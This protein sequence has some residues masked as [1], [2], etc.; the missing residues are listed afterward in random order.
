MRLNEIL[1]EDQEL[2]E[3]PLLNKIGSAVGKAAG[4]AAKAVG[5]VAG[6]IAGLGA[7][8]KK[9]FQAGKQ[10]VAGAGD[11]PAAGTTQPGAPAA[12]GGGASTQTPASTGTTS[13][14]SGGPPKSDTPFGRLSQAA[15][16]QDPDA[17][18]QPAGQEK[19]A[20]DATAQPAASTAQEKPQ[21][22]AEQPAAGTAQEKPATTTAAA[23]AAE[24]PAAQEKPQANAEQP[25][26]NDA[27][28][29]KVQQNVGKLPPEQQKELMAALMADPEVKKAL[30]QPA[31]EQPATTP[32]ADAQPA[33]KPGRQRDARGRF[34]SKDTPQPTAAPSQAEIDADRNRIIQQ[35]EN[36][37]R[38]TTK[39][40]VEN[41]PTVDIKPKGPTHAEKMSAMASGLKAGFSNPFGGPMKTSSK[42]AASTEINDTSGQMPVDLINK[43]NALED[44]EKIDLYVA[45]KGKLRK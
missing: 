37:F 32:A 35:Q 44:N 31:A 15:A 12:S 42:T 17:P 36:L 39:I 30:E 13:A 14:A 43:V 23:P 16:G 41:E 33:A 18:A 20:A 19:P 28:F 8:A 27:A 10:T 45:L 40:I 5:A 34:I 22:G 26:A 11:S 1:T 29:Q 4:G 24:Q 3:G 9:G 6:G 2:T 25:A 7:A 21:A 38:R